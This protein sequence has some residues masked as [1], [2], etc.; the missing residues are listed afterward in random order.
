[1]SDVPEHREDAFRGCRNCRHWDD[2]GWVTLEPGGGDAAMGECR[3]QPPVL[4][5]REVR[6]CGSLDAD[7][8]DMS[9]LDTA[10]NMTAWPVTLEYHWCGQFDRRHFGSNDQ[11]QRRAVLEGPPAGSA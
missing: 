8:P 4:T 3:R 7:D 11:R 1:M 10:R 9:G 5:T 6:K 2:D